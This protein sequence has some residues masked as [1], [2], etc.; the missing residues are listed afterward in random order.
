MARDVNRIEEIYRRGAARVLMQVEQVTHT[1]GGTVTSQNPSTDEMNRLFRVIRTTLDLIPESHAALM[2]ITEEAHI[3]VW[4][5]PTRGG[6][7]A[8][9]LGGS[10]A[11]PHIW[12]NR[13]RMREDRNREDDLSFTFLHELGHQVDYWRLNRIMGSR[14]RAYIT[15]D[16]RDE[17]PI[18]FLC[19]LTR[20]HG[21]RTRFPSEHFANVYAD[22]WYHVVAGLSWRQAD[23]VN[24]QYCDVPICER[25]EAAAQAQASREGLSMPRDNIAIVERRYQAVLRTLPFQGLTLPV[26]FG[27]V[28]P[29]G[30]EQASL[31]TGVP[32]SR[33]NRPDVGPR[34]DGTLGMA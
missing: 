5:R 23:R 22:Y 12:L 6:G 7:A 30:G 18:G 25:N 24:R 14:N 10:E 34:R 9:P 21:S 33:A 20:D 26:T 11:T 3:R 19:L 28:R 1:R 16:I 31:S 8:Q 13:D 27:G 2:G 17:D 4:G 29:G 15:T 32:R